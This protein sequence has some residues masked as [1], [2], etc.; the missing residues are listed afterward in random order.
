MPGQCP[1]MQSL[2][3]WIIFNQIGV[4]YGIPQYK[5]ARNTATQE[6][7]KM[8]KLLFNLITV[9]LQKM[10]PEIVKAIRSFINRLDEMA[11]KTANPFDDMLI[12]IIKTLTMNED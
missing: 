10:S 6:I 4:C 7:K 3:L 12:D 11:S 9:V 8:E 5:K 2:D 1:R